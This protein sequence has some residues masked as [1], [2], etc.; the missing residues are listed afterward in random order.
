MPVIQLTL[1]GRDS[2]T[3]GVSPFLLSHGYPLRTIDP[4]TEVAAPATPKSPIQK[5]EAIVAKIKEITEWAGTEM[6][7]AQ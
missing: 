6:A 3:T 1:N 2:I 7:K 5:G 4:L